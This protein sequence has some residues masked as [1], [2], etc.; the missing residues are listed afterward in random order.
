MGGILDGTHY[1]PSII[2]SF[3]TFFPG[4]DDMAAIDRYC[5][6]SAPPESKVRLSPFPY[7]PSLSLLSS[8]SS[9]TLTT[10]SRMTST[11]TTTTTSVNR[12][13]FLQLLQWLRTANNRIPLL[14]YSSFNNNLKLSWSS[15]HK[16]NRQHASYLK[17]S[18]L[19]LL[20]NYNSN[21]QCHNFQ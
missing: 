12:R 18:P 17:L 1:K 5:T 10:S 16:Q 4:D 11:T 21:F 3:P 9:R 20:S 19:I 6:R 8:Y 13:P 15:I 7:I 14:S 2:L